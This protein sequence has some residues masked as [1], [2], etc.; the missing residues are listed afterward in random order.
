MPFTIHPLHPGDEAHLTP[1]TDGVFDN[2]IDA[3]ASRDYLANPDNHL[4]VARD[5]ESI[6]GFVSATRQIHPDKPAGELFIQEIGV[7]PTHRRQGIATALMRALF[8]EARAGGCT[9]AWLAV[10]PDDAAAL[11]FYKSL[12]GKAPEKQL[13]VD[14]DLG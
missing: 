14:F 3:D 12:G 1:I 10:D 4:I 7:A 13:H 6:V 9:L 5:G 11:A 2:L 8:E